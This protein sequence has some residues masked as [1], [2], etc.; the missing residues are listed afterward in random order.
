[1]LKIQYTGE[2]A[3]H[4]IEFK[5]V[6]PHI[7]Q[8]MGNFPVKDKGFICYRDGN[9]DDKWSYKDYKTVFRTVEG[10]VQFSND[11]SVYIAPPEPEPE[12]DPAPYIPTEEEL[13]AMFEQ[14][15][16]DKI[17]LSKAMLESFLTDNPITS[18]A[19][20]NTEGIYAVTSEKQTLMM[21]QYMTYQIEKAVNPDA[22]L[23]WNESG[24]SCEEWTEHDFLEL[25]LEIK[26]YV[27]PL[28]SYQQT[29]EEQ[30]NACTAQDVLDAIE[31]DYASVH[32]VH[33]HTEGV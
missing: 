21:S 26:A 7:V 13:A 17:A 16:K 14:R 31:I 4:E 12:P 29:L 32:K 18:M 1:M 8:I 5:K 23:R 9:E 2:K 22:T 27:Y 15:K 11:G 28:V 3:S 19:H 20:N 24:K 25:I 30:I 33:N 10:G 6:T